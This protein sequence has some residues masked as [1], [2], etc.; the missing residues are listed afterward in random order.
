MNK[1]LEVLLFLWIILG[2][3][4]LAV[5]IKFNKIAFPLLSVEMKVNR[6]EAEKI[7][8]GYFKK[9]GINF[10][11]DYDMV[12][13][14]SSDE[15][16]ALYLER[17]YPIRKVNEF[18]K[19]EISMWYWEVRFFKPLIEE[20]Y[21]IFVKPCGKIKGFVCKL[22]EDAAGKFLS[23]KEALALA[24]QFLSRQNIN[25][26][27]YILIQSS[28]EK[29]K[30]RI[31]YNFIWEKKKF[32]VK[33]ATFQVKIRVLGDK[34]GEFN[35]YL[36]IPESAIREYKKES[37]RGEFISIISSFLG[38][39]IFIL[40]LIVVI[41]KF[42]NEDLEW[43]FILPLI[44]IM[45]IIIILE[46][47]NSLNLTKF[48][49]STEMEMRTFIGIQLIS[50]IPMV[51]FGGIIIFLTGTA[52]DS[53]VR[54]V[55]KEMTPPSQ[56]FKFN[57]LTSRN[58]ALSAIIGYS[59]AFIWIGYTVLLYMFG[60]KFLGIWMPSDA[61]YSNMLSTTF[62]FLFSLSAGFTASFFEEFTFRL[63]AISFLKKYLRST[64]LAVL[65][66]AIIWAFQHSTYPVFPIYFRGIELSIIGIALGY[67]F[68]KYG[69]MA[70]II[71][72]YVMNTLTAGLPLLKADNLYFLIS[73][74][75]TIGG[76]LLLP[77]ILG[78]ISLKRRKTK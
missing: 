26:S 68:I 74:I 21:R 2:I 63:F 20:E 57:W 40:S 32:K 31:D 5:A 36:K 16:S 70:T 14:F 67:T 25:L 4:G 1:K 62:P 12:S 44:I 66:S 71:A 41:I 54:D 29:Q 10:N 11:R 53:L 72:H 30:A 28:S 61:S 33:D 64:F 45:G 76:A 50:L 51:L 46:E 38:I 15:E 42:K 35:Q 48:I 24:S 19:K 56:M 23:L 8:L 34:I 3:F 78:L 60:R 77:I 6:V 69:I 37:A 9:I 73:W 7:A 39:L 52:G 55:F 58:F 17:Y 43:R 65:I 22:N 27:L 47:I 18:T 13:I 75:I 59:F 49:Y